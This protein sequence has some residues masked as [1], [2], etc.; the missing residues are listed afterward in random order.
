[1]AKAGALVLD[2]TNVKDRGKFNPTHKAPGDY[3]AQIKGC[4]LVD[5]KS[6]DGQQWVWDIKIGAS[7]YPYYTQ[8][9]PD[10]LWK[11]RGL[12]AA[13]GLNVPKKRVKLDPSRVIGRYIGVT[14]DDD[15]YE[16]KLK[17]IIVSMFPTSELEGSDDDEPD[18]DDEEEEEDEETEDEEE[19]DE[20][21][22]EE[23]DEEEPPPPPK[24]SKKTKAKKTT[25]K[26]EDVD[27]DE[28]EELDIEDI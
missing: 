3:K 14:L 8:L 18:E 11:V 28:L 6:G 24:K 13:A 16:G 23:E 25:R 4:E 7:T 19:E 9:E 27:D 15:E 26:T 1:M 21:D 17:S 5:K 2:F 22:E 12:F 20:D 10:V